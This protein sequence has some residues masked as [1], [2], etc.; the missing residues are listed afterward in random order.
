MVTLDIDLSFALSM[1]PK[2]SESGET[3]RHSALQSP[4]SGALRHFFS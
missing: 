3:V 4:P 1:K 2:S